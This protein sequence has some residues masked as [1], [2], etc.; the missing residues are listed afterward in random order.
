VQPILKE[1]DVVPEIELQLRLY[2]RLWLSRVDLEEA[3]GSIDEILNA[4]LPYPRH[5]VSG[6]LL[7]SLTTALVVSYARPFVNSC[8]YSTVEEGTLPGS[9]LRVF[10]SR[11]REFHEAVIGIRNRE[12]AH[13][14][15]DILELSPSGRGAVQRVARRPFRKIELRALQHMIKKLDKEI[16]RRCNELRSTLPLNVWL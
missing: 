6:P 3:N 11:E 13:S 7:Q 4:N 1:M 5:D 9:L 2:R 8:D 16:Y 12:V 14:D 10:T 15:A